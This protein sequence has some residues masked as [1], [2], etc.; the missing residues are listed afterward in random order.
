M[1]GVKDEVVE[2]LCSCGL[3]GGVSK[4]GLKQIADMAKVMTFSEGEEVKVQDTRG[5][6]FHLVLEGSARVT[7]D[8]RELSVVG[9][10]DS[11]GEMALLDGKPSSATVTAVEPMKTL[12]LSSWNFRTLLRKEPTIMERVLLEVVGRLRQ[13][14]ARP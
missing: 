11:I 9:P 2:Q 14:D 1:G 5:T 7:H 12:S 13:A 4:K 10:G 3:F 8:G 6:R